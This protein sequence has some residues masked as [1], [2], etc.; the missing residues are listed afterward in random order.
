M[1]RVA[2]NGISA[3]IDSVGRVRGRIDLDTIG[4]A[5]VM[6]PSPGNPTLYARAGD[7]TLLALLLVGAL[8]IGW[9]L[10][11]GGAPNLSATF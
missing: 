4:Y 10:R 3:V 8:P 9:R 7:W 2:N 11:T 1:I 6:L 5:D